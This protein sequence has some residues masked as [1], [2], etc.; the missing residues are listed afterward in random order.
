MSAVRLPPSAA[1]VWVNCPGSARIAARI[2]DESTDRAEGIAAHWCAAEALRG[3][4]PAIG[5]SA[6]NGINVTQKM[7]EGAAL[8][9]SVVLSKIGAGYAQVE[10]EIPMSYLDGQ[11]GLP[12]V[13]GV[14][15]DR[16]TLQVVEYKYGHAF[17]DAF[18]NWESIAHALGAF[19]WLVKSGVWAATAAQHIAAEIHVV[20][21]RNYDASG[22]VRTWR[23]RLDQLRAHRNTLACQA[24]LAQQPTAPV[25]TGPWCRKCDARHRCVAAQQAG[26]E[27]AEF[28]GTVAAHD[29]TPEQA[30]F[31]LRALERAREQLKARAEGL[32]IQLTAAARGGA[33]L[34]CHELR[35]GSGREVWKEGMSGAA[36]AVAALHGKNIAKPIEALTPA[37]AREKGVPP[38]AIADMIHRPPGEIKLAPATTNDSRKIFGG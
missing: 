38:D 27:I 8:Y 34:P 15:V 22:P 24:A 18:E 14:G 16:F 23:V 3:R 17:I 31:E 9:H 28:A 37:Q 30:S 20:Q 32:E 7:I 6:P 25:K 35:R 4:Y 2:P 13:F 1:P 33:R 21:P 10:T 5:S 11:T 36:I 29:L 26:Y 19:D 12:D